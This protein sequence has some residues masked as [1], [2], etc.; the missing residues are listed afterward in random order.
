MGFQ[1]NPRPWQRRR[2]GKGGRGKKRPEK[3]GEQNGV[4][5]GDQGRR[6]RKRASQQWQS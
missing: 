5:R 1:G 4:A 3:S 6:P 2:S